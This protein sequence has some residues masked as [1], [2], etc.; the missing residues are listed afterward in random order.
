MPT[1][2]VIIP[3]FNAESSLDKC[4]RSVLQQTYKDLEL[5]LVNDGSTDSSLSV[6]KKYEQTDS[7]VVVIDKENEGAGPT[8]N[9]GMRVAQGDFIAFVDADDW[10]EFDAYEKCLKIIQEKGADLLV[11]GIK[12]QTD[13]ISISK[14]QENTEV[15]NNDE[16]FCGIQSCR[17]QYSRLFDTY[18]LNSPANKIYKNKIIKDNQI[19][20]PDLRRMQ[21]CVFNVSYYDKIASIVI[22]HDKFYNRV[23]NSNEIEK[24]K[25]PKDY[26]S[27]ASEF[28][29]TLIKTVSKWENHSAFD[30]EPFDRM[31]A[32]T[33]EGAIFVFGP[34]K[35]SFIDLYKY[36][37]AI[38]CDKD[39]H[40]FYKNYVRR[41]KHIR[42]I[43]FA[44]RYR[45]N[46][47]VTLYALKR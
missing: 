22:L 40:S 39:V 20:F 42:K 13:D 7:R 12:V 36:I 45:M 24:K 30:F 6:C 23:W 10:V 35:D 16:F 37:R 47:L 33:I 26:V 18:N 38:I 1:L 43:Q 17:E 27:C 8:R 34:L 41:A 3:V 4:I 2:S 14:A 32:N 19:G 44:I 21:D 28:Y 46:L 29:S 9:T 5:I 31:Y 11:F 15:I 25:L